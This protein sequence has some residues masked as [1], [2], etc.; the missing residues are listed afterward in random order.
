MAEKKCE[1]EYNQVCTMFLQD[2][3]LHSAEKG[4]KISDI[5]VY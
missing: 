5:R 3:W 2:Y 4:A 1:I